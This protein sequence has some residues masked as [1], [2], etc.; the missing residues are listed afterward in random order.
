[1][2][3]FR[4]P[5]GEDIFTVE[6]EVKGTGVSFYPFD[7]SDVLSFKGKLSKVTDSV[8]S[9]LNLAT[10]S[11]SP[12]K[13]FQAETKAEYLKIIEQAI[14]FIKE[15]QLSKLVISR[16]KLIE[17]E[18]QSIDLKETFTQ[19]CKAYP[20]AFVYVFSSQGKCW[21]GAFSELLGKY[22]KKTSHFETMS[23]AGT[24]PIEES[25]GPKEI[26]EQKP[27]TDFILQVLQKYSENVK[28]SETYD[29]ISGNIKHLRNDFSALIK[30]EQ[31]DHIISELHPTPA[32]CGI[33]TDFCRTAIGNFELHPRNYYSGYIKVEDADSVH[34]FV[35]LR[36]AEL[37][38][39]AA[40]L[41][42][43][44][45]ITSESSPE[46]EWRET[47]LKA[48]AIGRNLVFISD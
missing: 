19:L 33:P 21:V 12:I 7:Q 34:Y 26:E 23:L 35:N 16:R 44:G 29:H 1:M 42:V 38:Q 18:N 39:N 31:L 17:F 13:D 30:A 10:D 5:F 28:Q 27:V 36:C 46:K 24:L 8:L 2:L 4:F 14:S 20:N 22:D 48:Q 15:N 6:E 3:Y 32:V 47:E 41:Y 43:G 25:W 9:N 40:L 11:L 45:G 37:F